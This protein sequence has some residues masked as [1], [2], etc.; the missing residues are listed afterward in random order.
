MRRFLLYTVL[1]F[2]LA[3]ILDFAAGCFFGIL[4]S[5]AT[6]GMT[7][8][9]EYLRRIC[10]DDILILGS[11]RAQNHYVPSVLEDS[12]GVT[13]YN[14]GQGGCGIIPAYV[15]YKMVARRSV[16]KLVIYDVVP[17]FDYLKDA[18]YA[19]YLGII[20]Q[21]ADDKIA[22][23]VILD[24][25]DRFER[26]RLLS[27]MYRNNSK[28]L[29]NIGDVRGK[30][31]LYKGYS[32]KYGEWT[33]TPVRKATAV[34]PYKVDSL[35]LSYFERLIQD[36][37]HDGASLVFVAS[38]SYSRG[39]LGSDYSLT[40]DLCEKYGIP[41][42]NNRVVEGITEVPERFF[43]RH[44]LNHQGAVAYTESLVAQIKRYV[45]NPSQRPAPES[46]RGQ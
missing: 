5:K 44:H 2:S 23:D 11:S 3:A 12:L 17:K 10:E 6:A 16:P 1:F 37:L 33:P 43:D 18:T 42:L 13:C 7:F 46:V 25:S 35:K 36:V 8:R 26:L 29:T 24:F 4:K 9:S 28:L 31:D 45:I 41:F 30:E 15:W 39:K 22:R 21:D 32:P 20:R 14:A 38:P 34:M 27:K 19:K 40:I